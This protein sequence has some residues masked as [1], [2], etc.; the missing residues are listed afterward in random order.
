MIGN[1]YHLVLITSEPGVSD[2]VASTQEIPGNDAAGPVPS[3]RVS[4]TD[5]GQNFR[6]YQDLSSPEKKHSRTYLPRELLSPYEVLNVY[7]V[8]YFCVFP[9]RPFFSSYF[10]FYVTWWTFFR[11]I[12]HGCPNS[13]FHS[14]SMFR[15]CQNP[16][17]GTHFSDLFV[18]LWKI[19]IFLRIPCSRKAVKV[20]TNNLFQLNFG[21]SLEISSK[22]FNQS[23]V[24]YFFATGFGSLDHRTQGEQG[25]S[26]G[27]R[28]EETLAEL[29][30]YTERWKQIGLLRQLL[31][32]QHLGSDGFCFLRSWWDGF[33]RAWGEQIPPQKKYMYGMRIEKKEGLGRPYRNLE[34][35]IMLQQFFHVLWPFWPPLRFSIEAS[36]QH[37]VR[38]CPGRHRVAHQALHG[39][40][41]PWSV[42]CQFQG[43]AAGLGAAG[44]WALQGVAWALLWPEEVKG[45]ESKDGL[46][47]ASENLWSGFGIRVVNQDVR[48]NIAKQKMSSWLTYQITY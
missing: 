29:G 19:Q 6:I 43:L 31:E 25:G 41:A 8:P 28:V 38:C 48:P 32:W 37:P 1:A 16:I 13:S 40:T 12:W 22:I 26:H 21:K 30:D 35:W 11:P 20:C 15:R 18:S 17:S 44:A 47:M 10:P 23:V 9:Q 27:E 5:A 42:A 39:A 46:D 2:L 4:F 14:D 34:V 7:C 3:P 45:W 36:L 33:G 24:L